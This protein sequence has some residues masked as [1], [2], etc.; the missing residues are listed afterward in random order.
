[1]AKREAAAQATAALDK[2][3]TLSKA[4]EPSFLTLS[5]DYEGGDALGGQGKSG[6]ELAKG[7][8]AEPREDGD[9]LRAERMVSFCESGDSLLLTKG[10]RRMFKR[11]GVAGSLSYCFDSIRDAQ[12]S[13]MYEAKREGGDMKD[14]AL[15]QK[16]GA[17]AQTLAA[18]I[19]QKAEHEG[20]E[21]LDFSDADDYGI[22]QL[23]SED[24][25][26]ARGNDDLGNVLATLLKAGKAPT[27][28]QHF[29]AA[30]LN[31]KKAKDL[32]KAAAKAIED[33]HKMHKAS[34]LAKE[35]L[36]KAG[37]K[38]AADDD[39]DFDHAG[40]MAKL[41]KA[42]SALSSM[43][44][45]SKAASQHMAKAAGNR[46]PME[47]TEDYTVPPGIKSKS[48][49]EMAHE[50]PGAG[51]TG[52]TPPELM[53][54]TL[55]PG[56]GAKGTFSKA[57]MT[58]ALRL[59]AAEGKVEALEKLPA[60]PTHGRRPAAFDTSKLFGANADENASLFKG[61]NAKALESDDEEIRKGAVGRVLGN[62]VLGGHGRSVFDNGFH[63]TAG[64]DANA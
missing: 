15:A 16:L 28:A 40:A 49:E 9:L 11:M 56:K 25:A 50:G 42:F 54:D 5:A 22:S 37:K 21:A 59:A 23:L 62:M 27:K 6:H 39:G 3:L 64:A 13:L 38:P 53:L 55:F 46:G 31:M 26:M 43:K 36:V 51:E 57:E 29:E 32:R 4:A 63:G 8:R 20:A 61:V 47:G 1:M 7:L 58:M 10:D 14:K 34:Y 17:L 30:K 12:R 35:A 33:V 24:L 18:V 60:G 45:F 19:G 44:T 2:R 41:Q 52:S 48:N